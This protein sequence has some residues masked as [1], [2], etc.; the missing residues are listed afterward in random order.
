MNGPVT[1]KDVFIPMEKIIGGQ[2]RLGF[3]WNMLMVSQTNVLHCIVMYSRESIILNCTILYVYYAILL[4][5]YA[6]LILYYTIL[7]YTIL[8][9]TILYYT[10]L[11][12]IILYYTKLYY[13][14]LYYT[15]LYYTI[16]Y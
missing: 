13:T 1:G 6:I 9:Y 8:Y 12:Y 3:G 2:K 14:K 11:C 10:I 5:Y 15:K 16:L 7:Y 4:L